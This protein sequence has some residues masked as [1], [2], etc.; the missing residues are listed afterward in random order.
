[1]SYAVVPL[2]RVRLPGGRVTRRP[3]GFDVSPHTFVV[4]EAGDPKAES[5]GAALVHFD[6]AVADARVE[7]VATDKD[8]ALSVASRSVLSAKLQGGR[9]FTGDKFSDQIAGLLPLR[10]QVDGEVV[11]WLGPGGEGQNRFYSAMT[12]KVK[13][14]QAFADTFTHADAAL[15]GLSLSGGVGAWVSSGWSIVSNQAATGTMGA[16]GGGTPLVNTQGDTDS[17]YSQADLVSL[18]G[19]SSDLVS[20]RLYACVDSAWGNGYFFTNQ[21]TFGANYRAIETILGAVTLASDTTATTS[22][23]LKFMR[24]GSTVQAYLN[25]ASILGPVTDTSEASGAGNRYVGFEAFCLNGNT[26]NG[27]V[28]DNYLGGDITALAIKTLAALGVG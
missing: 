17:L 13:H 4:L 5:S 3:F 19:Q 23:T 11:I 7:T 28:I 10:P 14:S 26:P 16:F 24:N 1:M 15:N 22:G 27:I 2:V 20:F 6:D 21:A 8:E 9:T 25:G 12:P 18:V